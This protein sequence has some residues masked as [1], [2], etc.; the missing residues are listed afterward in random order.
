MLRSLVFLSVVR[1]PIAA[2]AGCTGDK[3]QVSEPPKPLLFKLN[4]LE[5]RSFNL[6]FLWGKAP[7]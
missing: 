7:T 3:D 5:L 1:F 6:H 2:F 4:S